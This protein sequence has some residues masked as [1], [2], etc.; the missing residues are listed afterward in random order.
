MCYIKAFTLYR[1]ARVLCTA[2]SDIPKPEINLHKV[3]EEI[4]RGR[5]GR[6][7][8]RAKEEGDWKEVPVRLEKNEIQEV[9]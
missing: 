9:C 7:D 2:S 4:S 5:G 1:D 6:W 3:M 8:E